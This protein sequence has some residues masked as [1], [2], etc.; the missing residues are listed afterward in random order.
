MALPGAPQDIIYAHDG[1]G[2]HQGRFALGEGAGFYADQTGRV[3]AGWVSQWERPAT[4]VLDFH[5][6]LFAGDSAERSDER[7]VGHQCASPCRSRWPP[8]HSHITV[9]Q[10][11]TVLRQYCPTLIF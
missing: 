6:N 9:N 8:S 5:H 3:V 1:F 11:M 7:R 4:W 10:T 2:L